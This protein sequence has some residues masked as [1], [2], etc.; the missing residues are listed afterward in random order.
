MIK[1]RTFDTP[2]RVS[3]KMLFFGHFWTKKPNFWKFFPVDGF[4]PNSGIITWRHS[5]S[6]TKKI[7]MCVFPYKAT[8]RFF[9]LIWNNTHSK[10]FAFHVHSLKVL[11][12]KF[13]EN[14]STGK[15]F[16]KICFFGPKRTKK[17]LD[18]NLHN[19]FL[20]TPWGLSNMPSLI[21]IHFLPWKSVFAERE[22]AC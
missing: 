2:L 15:S 3:K 9:G 19:F 22:T 12:S 17:W 11:I 18:S 4:S 14:S 1:L 6:N 5:A 21:K 8:W 20:D 10:F 7:G 16:S 13:G